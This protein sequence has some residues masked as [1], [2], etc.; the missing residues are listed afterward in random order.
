MLPQLPWLNWLEVRKKWLKCGR[1]NNNFYRSKT[2]RFSPPWIWFLGVSL[3][4]PSVEKCCPI[5]ITHFLFTRKYWAFISLFF[6][7]LLEFPERNASLRK[8]SKFY[9][10]PTFAC[11]KKCEI[12]S[13][14]PSPFWEQ[15]NPHLFGL[16]GHLV[17][18]PH[19]IFFFLPH[20]R[21]PLFNYISWFSALK[22]VIQ[23]VA[24]GLT[25]SQITK[26]IFQN[27]F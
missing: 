22:G 3:L 13:I 25:H 9:V 21:F 7:L 2:A 20:F 4:L 24:I 1:M 14:F 27:M 11:G 10:F 26:N 18:P 19:E 17:E 15:K 6:S 16:A 5:I 8:S 12:E 23:G